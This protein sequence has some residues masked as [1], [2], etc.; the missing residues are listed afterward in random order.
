MKL[1]LVVLGLATAVVG[2]GCFG[3]GGGSGG[4][5]SCTRTDTTCIELGRGHEL[6]GYPALCVTPATY[7][8]SDCPSANLVGRCEWTE[9]VS[10]GTSSQT[11]H[12]YL[13]ETTLEEAMTD[14]DGYGDAGVFTPG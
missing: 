1:H 12:Y 3:F 8:A 6:A 9:T 10:G 11:F 2:A 5:G 7:S 14:C 13:P 4:G